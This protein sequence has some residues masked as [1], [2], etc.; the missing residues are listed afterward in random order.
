MER[1]ITLFGLHGGT[2]GWLVSM[3]TCTSVWKVFIVEVKNRM[4]WRPG[5]ARCAQ[6]QQPTFKPNF[7]T[8]YDVHYVCMVP[9]HCN[10]M[11]IS[12]CRTDVLQLK[13]WT[14][15]RENSQLPCITSHTTCT[16]LKSHWTNSSTIFRLISVVWWICTWVIGHEWAASSHNSLNI[17]RKCQFLMQMLW[18]RF[19]R[20]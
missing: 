9:F 13:P 5:I 16:T 11:W 4:W 15:A 2:L 20:T 7:F 14:T 18:V 3:K 10:L 1:L 8:H 12:N 17:G 19:H 6:L